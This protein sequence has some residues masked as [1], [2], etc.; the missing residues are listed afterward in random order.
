MPVIKLMHLLCS[1]FHTRAMH[2]VYIS[3][4]TMQEYVF[5]SYA[6]DII[7][8]SHAGHDNHLMVALRVNAIIGN[9]LIITE[10]L[11][12]CGEERGVWWKVCLRCGLPQQLLGRMCTVL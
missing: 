12:S 10:L 2:A 7:V 4:A 1:V 5:S 9:L 8:Y 6:L 11:F 3:E